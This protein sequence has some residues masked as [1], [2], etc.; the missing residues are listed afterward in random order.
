MEYVQ[1]YIDSKKLMGNM[2]RGFMVAGNILEGQGYDLQT[3]QREKN[4]EQ[5]WKNLNIKSGIGIQLARDVT[6][7]NS[8]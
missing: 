4:D 2:K 5:W 8:F 3:V 7:F 1:W 6:T